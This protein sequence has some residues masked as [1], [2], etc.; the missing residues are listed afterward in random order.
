[1]DVNEDG[2]TDIIFSNEKRYSFHLFIPSYTLVFKPAG[3]ARCS[4]ATAALSGELPND[5]S[6]RRQ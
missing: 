4:R 1:V 3:H 2:F 5:H 6:Q